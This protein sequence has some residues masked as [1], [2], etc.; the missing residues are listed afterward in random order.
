MGEEKA[1]SVSPKSAARYGPGDG[2]W[3]VCNLQLLVR[4][5]VL[6]KSIL[7][8]IFIHF[9]QNSIISTNTLFLIYAYV[10]NIP[11]VCRASLI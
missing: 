10:V 5:V 2:Y 11:K 3:K 1:P 4:G 6:H 9:F 8:S 7:H